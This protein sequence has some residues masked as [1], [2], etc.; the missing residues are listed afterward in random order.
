[1]TP[2][3]TGENQNLITVKISDGQMLE[4]TEYHKWYIQKQDS[5]GMAT[6]I[7]KK[8]TNELCIGDKIIKSTFPV[9]HGGLELDFSYASTSANQG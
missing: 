1:V 7:I 3:K 8:S 2:R 9:I 6:K 5:R 4:C